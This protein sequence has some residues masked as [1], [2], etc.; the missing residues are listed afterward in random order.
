MNILE[1]SHKAEALVGQEMFKVLDRAKKLELSGNKVFHLELG[2]PSLTPPKE[3]LE[4]TINALKNGQ[5][6]YTSSSGL[7]ELREEIGRQYSL[8]QKNI[9]SV[10]E[11]V[12]SP[13]NMLVSQ[14]MDLSCNKGDR[15]VLFSPCFPTY[16]ASSSYSGL[17]VQDVPLSSSNGFDLSFEIIDKAISLSPRAIVVNSANNPT[18]RVYSQS[19][20]EYLARR[21]YELGIWLLSDETYANID[22]GKPFFSLAT[23]D[24]PKLVV[25]SSFSKVFSIPGYRIGYA[26]ANKKVTKKLTLMNSTLFSCCSEFTQIGC[27][28]GLKQLDNYGNS[29]KLYYQ[30]ITEVIAK[31]LHSSPLVEFSKPDSAFY[32]FIDISKT[33]LKDVEFCD[34]LLSQ[35]HTAITPG[36]SFGKQFDNFIRIAVCGDIEDVKEGVCRLVNFL[37]EYDAKK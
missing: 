7:L 21:C 29:V 30:N 36:S 28:A 19:V 10:E 14:F 12:I 13:A 24:Y 33:S 34:L 15:I 9:I 17:D 1:F 35:K 3:I 22:F 20:L 32:F 18:G 27:L 8:N 25:I 5:T 4:E 2:S 26:I 23:L 6:G 31:I 11:V 37:E 16:L